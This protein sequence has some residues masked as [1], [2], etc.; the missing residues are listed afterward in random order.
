MS[1]S[2]GNVVDPLEF[3]D[4]YGADALRFTLARGAN[5]GAD[6][7]LA[8]EWV[9]G[10]RNFATKLWNATRFAMMNGATLEGPLPALSEL[11]AIDQWI[12]SRLNETIRDVDA[13]IAEFEFDISFSL[14]CLGCTSCIEL[15]IIC[16]SN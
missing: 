15:H 13:L 9:G 14:R 11:G 10:S 1:K 8:E 5:P 16:C 7:A 6:Q 2:R 4:K 12:L 3:M